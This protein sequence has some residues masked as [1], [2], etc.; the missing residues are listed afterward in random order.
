MISIFGIK[1]MFIKKKK[2]QAYKPG[3]VS[4]FAVKNRSK[5]PVIY[6]VPA[7]R[8]ESIDLPTLIS[9]SGKAV[10]GRASNS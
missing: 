2:V 6:L 8:Q 1:Q 9:P 10:E 7:S 3:S 4:F 5:V